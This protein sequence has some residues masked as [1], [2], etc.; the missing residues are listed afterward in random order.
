MLWC[1]FCWTAS[2]ATVHAAA[3]YPFKPLPT[4][5]A[6]RIAAAFGRLQELFSQL[7]PYMQQADDVGMP[8]CFAGHSLGMHQSLTWH[9]CD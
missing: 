5:L 7:R 6:C 9:A 4:S 8:L 3:P 2:Q 1:C